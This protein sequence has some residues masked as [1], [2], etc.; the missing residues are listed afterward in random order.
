MKVKAVGGTTALQGRGDFQHRELANSRL[1]T[2]DSF[3]GWLES[4]DKDSQT[5]FPLKTG[6]LSNVDEILVSSSDE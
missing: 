6:I 4:L 1:D 3:R 5:G 2:G